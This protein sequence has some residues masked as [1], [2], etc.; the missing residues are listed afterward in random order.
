MP[1]FQMKKTFL[2]GLGLDH[3]DVRYDKP[4]GRVKNFIKNFQKYNLITHY[5]LDGSYILEK[6]LEKILNKKRKNFL[7]KLLILK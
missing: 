6:I 2:F 5:T 1:I 4:K 3:V 7:K